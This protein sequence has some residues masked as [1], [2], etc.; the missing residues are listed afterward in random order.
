MVRK[1]RD[2]SNERIKVLWFCP[3]CRNPHDKR[4][5]CEQSYKKRMNNGS[6]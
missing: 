4:I 6:T 5:S 1:K 3:A 2:R